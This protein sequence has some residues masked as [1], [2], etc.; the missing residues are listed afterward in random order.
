MIVKLNLS[1]CG[2]VE[3]LLTGLD[4]HQGSWEDV[5]AVALEMCRERRSC[6]E[7]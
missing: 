3:R 1:G 7:Y 5:D 2:G 6:R 4:D